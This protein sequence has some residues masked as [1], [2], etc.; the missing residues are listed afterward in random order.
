MQLYTIINDRTKWAN[1]LNGLDIFKAKDYSKEEVNEFLKS[2]DGYVL[3][4]YYSW[5]TEYDDCDDKSYGSDILYHKINVD[6]LLICDN[7]VVGVIFVTKHHEGGMSTCY[8]Y[9]FNAIYFDAPNEEKGEKWNDYCNLEK[10]IVTPSKTEEE[11]C[12][13]YLIKESEKPNNEEYTKFKMDN[14]M[15]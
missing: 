3:K 6:E 2:V 15:Y 7:K 8:S 12:K 1:N 13:V 4:D 5:E 9:S 14:V 10:C 11:E